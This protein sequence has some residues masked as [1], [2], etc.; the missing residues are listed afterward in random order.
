MR[1]VLIGTGKIGCGYLVPLFRAAGWDVVVAG[2]SPRTV[3][4]M[5]RTGRF[6]VRVTAPASPS[7]RRSGATPA[8]CCPTPAS[9]G[10]GGTC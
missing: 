10:A 1:V 4:R 7:G 2:R 8:S 5:N 3:E 6:A 9:P